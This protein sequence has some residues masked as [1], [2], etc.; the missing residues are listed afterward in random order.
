M[1]SGVVCFCFRR[2]AT[3]EFSRGFQATESATHSSSRQRRLN[4][5]T[6]TP[7]VQ[8]LRTGKRVKRGDDAPSF[9]K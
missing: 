7:K 3:R 5:G 6:A 2:I 4:A 8:N 1:P 9:V